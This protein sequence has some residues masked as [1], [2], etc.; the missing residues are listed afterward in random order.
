M[1]GPVNTY[2]IVGDGRGN[3]RKLRHQTRAVG[4]DTMYEPYVIPVRAAQILGVYKLAYPTQLTVVENAHDGT[5]TGAL[6]AHVPVGTT[7]KKVR[8]RRIFFDSHHSTALATPTAPRLRA[9]YF[10]FTG[11]ASG[12][13]LTPHKI[14]QDYPTATLDLRSAV[15]GLTVTLATVVGQAG[16]TGAVTAVGAYTPNQVHLL[17]GIDEDEWPVLTAGTGIAVFQQ[18]AGTA[19]DTRKYNLN[20]VWDEIDVS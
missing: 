17:D 8:I 3:D 4:S 15:T 7:G 5:T 13:Q 12:T 6:W 14:D 9:T 16:I 20:M 10:T 18:T 11:T 19:S 2:G 1:A